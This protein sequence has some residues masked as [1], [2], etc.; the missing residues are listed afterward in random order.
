MIKIKGLY[1]M[2]RTMIRKGTRRKI[3]ILIERIVDTVEENKK[4]WKEETL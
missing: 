4:L 2:R 1:G 3:R